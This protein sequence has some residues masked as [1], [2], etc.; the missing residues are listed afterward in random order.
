MGAGGAGGFAG[1]GNMPGTG[2]TAAMTLSEAEVLH[3]AITANS[4]EI[5]QGELA[6]SLA[7]SEDILAHAQTEI[8]HHTISNEMAQ[9]VA[10]ELALEP[11]DN[12]VS[13]DLAL[14]WEAEM[15]EI[16][17]TTGPE[18]ELS[19]MRAQ[20]RG[21][22]AVLALLDEQLI[23]AASSVALANY[24]HAVR[25]DIESHLTSAQD[26]LVQIDE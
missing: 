24:L 6:V 11:L 5:T 8:S 3:A 9:T 22:Q 21:H 2:G 1:T 19:Y 18:F 23:P 13:Q 17:A 12:A 25:M 4:G 7:A 15:G 26:I 14:D 16:E 20:V 10:T